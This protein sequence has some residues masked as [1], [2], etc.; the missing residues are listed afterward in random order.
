M[1]VR[2]KYCTR[3]MKTFFAAR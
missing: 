1:S 3:R 2:T